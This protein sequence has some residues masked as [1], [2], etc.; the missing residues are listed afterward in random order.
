MTAIIC[1]VSLGCTVPVF[2]A[3]SRFPNAH[4]TTQDADFW[5]LLQSSVMQLLNL[6]TIVYP[7]SQ[8]SLMH[9]RPWFWAWMYAMTS[10]LC[11]LAATAL[12]VLVPVKWS[13]VLSFGGSVA[14]ALL[15]LQ[16]MQ[17]VGKGGGAGGDV[18]TRH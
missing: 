13:A 12:Y 14:Q 6:L 9:W 18:K 11:L 4:G 1:A 15:I 8:K 5:M 7:A 16:F 10:C 17:V 2:V 3:W